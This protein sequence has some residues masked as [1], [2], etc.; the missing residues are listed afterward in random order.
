MI[1]RCWEVI[2]VTNADSKTVTRDQIIKTLFITKY[3]FI[4][5]FKFG[6]HGKSGYFHF[7]IPLW[8]YLQFYFDF[9]YSGNTVDSFDKVLRERGLNLKHL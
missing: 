6:D 9:T 7:H 5:T 1:T 3:F 8:L 4:T 2:I